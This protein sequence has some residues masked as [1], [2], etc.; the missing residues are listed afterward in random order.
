MLAGPP[1]T[2]KK[3]RKL[4]KEMSWPEVI[5]WQRLRQRPAGFKFRRQHPAGS[6]ILDF[7]CSEA[8]LAIEVDGMAHEFDHRAGQDVARNDWLEQR[9]IITLRV[10]A[11]DVTRDPDGVAESIIA[12]CVERSNPLHQPSAGPPPRSGEETR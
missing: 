1:S 4:R 3:A 6:F 9:G 12:V 7:Y 2:V 8:L 5:L 10:S 11:G